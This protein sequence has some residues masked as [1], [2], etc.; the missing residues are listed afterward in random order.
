MPLRDLIGRNML[1]PALRL[2]RAQ[3]QA[4]ADPV[5]LREAAAR[6]D[7]L[8]MPPPDARIGPVQCGDVPARWVDVK[9]ARRDRVVLYLHGGAFISE[10][11]NFHGALLARIGREAHARALMPSY[12]LA[13]EHRYP[14]ALDDVFAAYRWLLAEGH[15]AQHIV[16]AGDSAGGNL[17]LA[18]LLRARDEGLPLP[19][20]AVALSPVADLTFSG[21][22]VKRND[23][24]DDMF[25]A[26]LMEPLIPVYLDRAELRRHPYVS[27]LFGDFAGLPPLLLQVGSTELLLDDAVRVAQRW[28]LAR[29]EV[30]HGMPHV[31]AGFDFLAEARDATRRIGHFVRD[32][33]AEA[34]ASMP[35]APPAAGSAPAAAA[36][37]EEAAV[38]AAD[39]ALAGN[40]EPAATVPPKLVF[41]LAAEPL[42]YLVLAVASALLTLALLMVPAYRPGLFTNPALWAATGVVVAFVLLESRG[43][44]WRQWVAC[45]AATLLLGPACGLAV[46]LFVRAHAR[47]HAPDRK[48]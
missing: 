14:A 11:P 29:L 38:T 16:V 12:R 39:E 4:M 44:A 24:V 42:A 31:F 6:V 18:L 47:S 17:V 45:L 43:V 23:G 48:P 25:S 27:P 33:I 22:S 8:A 32:R 30:W 1:F 46:H 10:T 28:P 3:M 15:P 40:G 5:H 35:A 2:M 13:P 21:D 37:D 34:S 19:A 7:A 26:S 20:G 36:A 9:G 41:G